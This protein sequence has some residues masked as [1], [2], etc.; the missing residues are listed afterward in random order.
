MEKDK[1]LKI[2][3]VEKELTNEEMEKVSG[4]LTPIG[5]K[6]GC[7]IDRSGASNSSNTYKSVP[8]VVS[9]FP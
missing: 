2:T 4:G 5:C 1:D 3:S 6:C 9:Q 8:S 7:S